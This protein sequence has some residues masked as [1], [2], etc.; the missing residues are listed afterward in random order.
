MR[1]II[2]WLMMTFTPNTFY[3]PNRN[4]FYQVELESHRPLGLL[5]A[6]HLIQLATQTNATSL[7]I[8]VEGFS[9]RDTQRS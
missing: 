9:D 7:T 6:Q 1:K 2:H 5:A 8:D 4:P 3:V